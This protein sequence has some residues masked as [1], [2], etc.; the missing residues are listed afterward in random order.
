M[1]QDTCLYSWRYLAAN[2]SRGWQAG[3]HGWMGLC[4]PCGDPLL[5]GRDAMG[6]QI[7]HKETPDTL[8]RAI[9]NDLLFLFSL[10]L[11]RERDSA[12][13]HSSQTCLSVWAET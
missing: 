12:N 2:C 8:S 10:N 7:I 3:R 4:V 13:P 1:W 6:K 9:W 5:G 11:K